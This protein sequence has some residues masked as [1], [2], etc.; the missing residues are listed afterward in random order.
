[1]LYPWFYRAAID[2]VC[3]CGAHETLTEREL[4]T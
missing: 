3:R 2:A 1:M 4:H